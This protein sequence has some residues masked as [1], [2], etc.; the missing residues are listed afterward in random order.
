MFIGIAIVA[1]LCKM[2]ADMGGLFLRGD[3]NKKEF[4]SG[5]WRYEKDTHF[6]TD[7][8]IHRHSGSDFMRRNYG[9]EPTWKRFAE[10]DEVAKL[11]AKEEEVALKKAAEEEARL[12]AEAEVAAKKKAEGLQTMNKPVFK[13]SNALQEQ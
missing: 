9:V 6:T 5:A 10:Q 13:L 12:I 11:R 4:M 3:W 2:N 7:P 8:Q 1:N